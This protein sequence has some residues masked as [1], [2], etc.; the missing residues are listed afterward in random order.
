MA[1]ETFTDWILWKDE[2]YIFINKPAQ[3]TS[4]QDRNTDKNILDLARQ[5]DP[6]VQLC[7][8]LDKETSG[9]LLIARNPESY[10]HASMQFEHREVTKTYLTIVWGSSGYKQLVIDTPILVT[11]RGVAKT[12]RHNGKESLTLV[13]T[14]KSWPRFSLLE[15]RPKSGRKHQ[16]RVHL[17]SKGHPVIS[18]SQ[19]GGEPV[20]LSK[21]KKKYSGEE[22]P[23]INRLALHAS[24]LE[25]RLLNDDSIKVEAPLPNDIAVVIKLLEKYG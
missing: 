23:M 2:N 13:N 22:K 12:D 4:L 18:D 11:G 14:L 9:V 20:Y 19:Y 3:V 7:H 15:C 24:S 1:R 25:I 17:A 6:D 21:L 5:F 10:R 16:I 8:R